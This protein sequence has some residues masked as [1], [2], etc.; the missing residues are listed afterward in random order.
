MPIDI[1]SL[2][3]SE[4][5]VLG[6]RIEQRKRQ[7][8][9]ERREMLRKELIDVARAEGFTITE[10]FGASISV[11]R[12]TAYANPSNAFQ[13]WHGRGKRPKWL[14]DALASGRSLE[15]LKVSP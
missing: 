3:F 13:L 4:L 9:I 14:V 6:A 15:S 11:E 8:L 7:V 5:K 12:G 10:L 2:T 1:E